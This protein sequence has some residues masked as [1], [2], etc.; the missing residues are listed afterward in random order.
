[1]SN[2][3][4]DIAGKVLAADERNIVKK[5]GNEGPLSSVERQIMERKIV[6]AATADEIFEQRRV[7]LLMKLA[8]GS[9]LSS[10][11][12]Q[13]LGELL[14]PSPHLLKHV[15]RAS[16]KKTLAD[17]AKELG[18]G[19]R[20]LERWL[21]SGRSC[22]PPD[23]PPFEQGPAAIVEWWKRMKAL[24][25]L[26]QKVSDRL[27]KLAQT[28][29]AAPVSEASRSGAPPQTASPPIS[30]PLQLPEGS[31]FAA[32]LG[33][34]RENEQIASARLRE[35]IESQDIGRIEAAQT[36]WSKAFESLRKAEKDAEQVLLATGELVRW[37]EV[38]KEQAEVLQS[39]N[40]SLRSIFVRVAT[41]VPVPA[42]L[43]QLL[44]RATQDELDRIFT[45]LAE[46]EYD[47]RRSQ[48][49]QLAA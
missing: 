14:P 9:S 31:G 23:L 42:D 29:P 36:G 8:R 2:L 1:M 7:S 6:S 25:R 46:N 48:P 24:G 16:L 20:A 41:K 32:A 13:E 19:E 18:Y 40:Q 3:T 45:H 4:P 21:E 22:D 39:L 49:F 5:V 43:Y 38:E 37:S 35:A 15:T 47:A 11:Q 34:C 33:R 28:T 17:Y 30:K 10:D 26:K 44:E 12:K 27:T